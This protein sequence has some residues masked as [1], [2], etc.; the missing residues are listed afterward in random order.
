MRNSV[1]KSTVFRGLLLASCL[2]ALCA[3]GE[4]EEVLSDLHIQQRYPWNGKV[5]IT[6]TVNGEAGQGYEIFLAATTVNWD[7]ETVPLPVSTVYQ[8]GKTVADGLVVSNGVQHLVWDAGTDVPRVKYDDVTLEVRA[9][10]WSD[11]VQLWEN[12]PY[13][14]KCNV[15]ASKPEEYGYYFWWGDTVG[16]RWKNGSGWDAV[17]GSRTGFSFYDCP[18][19][20]KSTSQLQSDGWIDATGNLVAAHDAATAHLGAPWRIPTDAEWDALLGNCDT[21]WTTKNGV[22][23]RLVKGRGTYA[24]KSIFLPAA[25]YGDGSD[26]GSLGSYGR[27]WSSTP[28][29]GSSYDAW[30]LRFGSGYFYRFDD[31]RYRGRSVRPLRGFAQ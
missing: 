18:T 5:D 28:N 22:Y 29:S 1:L 23:G 26:L 15:G 12:G 24:G 10:I 20:G 13:W 27:Y 30:F 2:S 4:G 11:S 6:F 31:D 21:E 14:A 7:G 8:Q 25:G 9:E 16:Y 17:D 3:W 19:Y